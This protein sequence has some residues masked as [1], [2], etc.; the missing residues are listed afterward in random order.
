M[1]WPTRIMAPE[2]LAD[3]IGRLTDDWWLT[4]R[5]GRP[6]GGR[7]E[8]GK[9]EE[10]RRLVGWLTKG[11]PKGGRITK[12]SGRAEGEV[13]SGERRGVIMLWRNY[14]IS[15]DWCEFRPLV[16]CSGSDAGAWC[17]FRPLVCCSGSDAGAAGTE[18]VTAQGIRR[19][20]QSESPTRFRHWQKDW[21]RM[22]LEKGQLRVTAKYTQNSGHS[23]TLSTNRPLAL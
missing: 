19:F 16:C 2:G 17:E 21:L 7:R 10:G 5:R 8:G 22:L 9:E 23:E 15:G 6:K 1:D 18:K 12:A 13:A 3:R 14:G 11:R 20:K 4:D